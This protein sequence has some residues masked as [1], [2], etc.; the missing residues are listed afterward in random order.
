MENS[1]IRFI[2]KTPPTGKSIIC[3]DNVN[4]KKIFSKIKNKNILTYGQSSNAQYRISNIR[5]KTN[6]SIF[7]L[8]Y[9][10]LKK[11]NKKV[12]NIQLRLLGKHNVLNAAAAVTV[13]LNLG[14]EHNIIKKSLLLT[15]LKSG[16]NAWQ[17]EKDGNIRSKGFDFYSV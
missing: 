15:L 17:F 9:K 5:Y 16:E 11:K 8:N 3:I 10:D 13:C 1:F 7:D 6:H 2:E 14:V 4:I 12:K